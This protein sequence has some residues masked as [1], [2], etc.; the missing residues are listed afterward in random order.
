MFR[1]YNKLNDK[2]PFRYLSQTH[3]AEIFATKKLIT[4]PISSSHIIHH[5][6]ETMICRINIQQMWGVPFINYYICRQGFSKLMSCNSYFCSIA[7]IFYS[8]YRSLPEFC[9]C[10]ISPAQ[11]SPSPGQSGTACAPV[12]LTIGASIP[13]R[14][15]NHFQKYT[16]CRRRNNSSSNIQTKT[17]PY[18]N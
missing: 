14:L 16:K 12:G 7:D 4:S 10:M 3:F 2:V 17:S 15:A 1:R 13:V 8:G 6:I 11:S 18:Y 9:V 5:E